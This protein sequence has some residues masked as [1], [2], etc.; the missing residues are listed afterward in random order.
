MN[1]PSELEKAHARFEVEDLVHAMDQV[2]P[3]ISKVWRLKYGPA[4]MT[5]KEIAEELGI[6]LRN[7]YFYC[8]EA[9]RIGKSLSD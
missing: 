4:R 7:V 9:R 6:P 8:D 5:A 1:A 3:L 2:N